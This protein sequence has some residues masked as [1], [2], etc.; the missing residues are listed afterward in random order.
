[1]AGIDEYEVEF[2]TTN[3]KN[4]TDQS[5][6]SKEKSII[7]NFIKDEDPTPF[8]GKNTLSEGMNGLRKF[9]WS[10]FSTSDGLSGAPDLRF[11]KSNDNT[12]VK[13]RNNVTVDIRA[14]TLLAKRNKN[15]VLNSGLKRSFENA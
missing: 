15:F 13:V 8:S 10:G 11:T 1:M 14:N 9:S 7:N 3:E 12:P 4:S 2:E 6:T 5:P